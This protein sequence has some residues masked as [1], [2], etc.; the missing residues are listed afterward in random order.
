MTSWF[1]ASDTSLREVIDLDLEESFV[2]TL[3][4]ARDAGGR[5]A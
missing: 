5:A 4:A 2:E 3:R 1:T